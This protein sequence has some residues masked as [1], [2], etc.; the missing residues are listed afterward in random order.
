[1]EFLTLLDKKILLDYIDA[2]ELI[3]ETEEDIRKMRS[4]DFMIDKVRGS[5]PEFPY[6][7]QSF[8]ISGIVEN[9]FNESDIK[10]EMLLLQQRKK[11][12]NR[13]KR[14]VDTWINTIP[15]RMQRI[16]RYRVF[17]RLS[18]NEVADKMG[19]NATAD[20]IRM[21]YFNFIKKEK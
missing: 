17:E 20:S 1:M 11:N 5:N 19:R 6:Q 8:S 18:W 7:A 14:E 12:A 13:I 15:I 21:E 3:K 9:C 2:C 16:I 10:K 4:K